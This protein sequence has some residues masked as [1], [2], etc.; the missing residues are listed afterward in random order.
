NKVYNKSTSTTATGTAALSGIESGDAV[1][2]TGTPTY[3]FGQATVGNG[4][5]ITTTGYTLGDVD[6]GNYTVTQPTLSANITAKVLS[7]TG[8]TGLNKEYNKSTSATA[9]GTAALSGIESGDAVT[10]TGTPVYTFGHAM[11]G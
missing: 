7:V 8:L 4:I 10:L 5:T 3:T 2:L 6:A 1:T 11:V 9:T